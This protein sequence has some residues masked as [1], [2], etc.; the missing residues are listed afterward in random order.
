LFL[1][2]KH[3][4]GAT[5]SF[6]G[7]SA[8]GGPVTVR[9]EPCGSATMRVVDPRGKP[10]K[11]RLPILTIRMIVTQGPSLSVVREKSEQL[12]ADETMLPRID[13]VNYPNGLV[14]D[15]DGRITLPAL[16]PGATY[17]L[18]DYSTFRDSDGAKVRREFTVRSGESLD[19]G[20]ILIEKPVG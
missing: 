1:D 14:P 11:G 8:A 9:L 16:I 4:L 3:K 7:K 13:P 20:D 10:A 18:F 2:S 19:L 6:S 5:V 17:R 15:A 12:C